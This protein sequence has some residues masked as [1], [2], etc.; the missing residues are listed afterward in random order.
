M[1]HWLLL[2]CELSQRAG[3]DS[4]QKLTSSWELGKGPGLPCKWLCQWEE[5]RVF[6]P[7]GTVVSSAWGML[8][9]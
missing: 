4:P 6:A 3:R 5:L 9:Q 1:S 8:L 2:W 7:L